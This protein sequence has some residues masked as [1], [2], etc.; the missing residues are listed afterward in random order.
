MAKIIYYLVNN[1]YKKINIEYL[2]LADELG[3]LFLL[4]PGLLIDILDQVRVLVVLQPAGGR[5]RGL[6]PTYSHFAFLNKL[7]YDI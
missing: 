3:E 1:I 6:R 7:L 5:S 2:E 4:Q